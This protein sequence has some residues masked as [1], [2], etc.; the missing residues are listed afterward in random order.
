MKVAVYYSNS[1]I[2]I[3]ERPTPQIKEGEILIEVKASGIC[4][5]DVM[6][7][8]RI[9]KAPRVLGHEIAG[10]IAESK[11]PKYK[12]DQRVFVSH[13]VPCNNCKY[14]LEG[15]QT[16]CET[17]HTGNYEPGGYSEFI[18]VPQINAE[19]GTYVLPDNISFEEATMIEPLACAV[20]G[21]RMIGVK[22][23][24]TVLVLGSGISGLL[25][26]ALCRSIGA[27]VIAT[28]I[29]EYRLN[30]AKEF[31]ADEVINAKEPLDLKADRIIICTG[32]QSA[33]NQAF[34]CI[35][36]KGVVLLFAIPAKN[37]EIPNAD[38]WRNELTLT[39]SYGAAPIDLEE[40]IKLIKDG[41]VKAKEM[42]THRLMLQDIKEGFRIVCEAKNSL[43]VVLTP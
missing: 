19:R 27:K 31:G 39:S 14:C 9:K 17:L 29:D 34:N 3:E 35:D 12:I 2:R 11:S 7:W 32:A 10:I 36:R 18:R 25:N 38:F 15:N 20:R 24:H 30:K 26:I 21:I 1:D 23:N 8:Y 22:K 42:I 37:I 40:A 13:H 43:K 28:D 6:Q 16:A 4:G 41:R 5:T 33:V